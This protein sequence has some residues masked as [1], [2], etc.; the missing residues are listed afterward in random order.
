MVGPSLYAG[1]TMD[2]L[3]KIGALLI[4]LFYKV[5]HL[6]YAVDFAMKGWYQAEGSFT[7]CRSFVDVGTGYVA[8]KLG[9]FRCALCHSEWMR[10][11]KK[12]RGY[13]HVKSHTLNSFLVNS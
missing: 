8:S 12:A 6:R 7:G 11:H 9:L 2:S 13:S 5:S 3:V 10:K 1:I 4:V